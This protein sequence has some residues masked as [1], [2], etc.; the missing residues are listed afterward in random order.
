MQRSF[1]LG[2]GGGGGGGS[3]FVILGP[4]LVG[5]NLDH[6]PSSRFVASPLSVINYHSLNT[7]LKGVSRGAGGQA[8]VPAGSGLSQTGAGQ[9]PELLTV[10]DGPR[11]H[12]VSL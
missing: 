11:A 7:V 3:A 8:G 4:F 10:F 2:G 5:A 12:L 9:S 1:F 6:P